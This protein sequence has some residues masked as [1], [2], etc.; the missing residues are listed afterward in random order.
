MGEYV[1]VKTKELNGAAL[2]WATA[3][4]DGWHPDSME[5]G[6]VVKFGEYR[7]AGNARQFDCYSPSTN[8]D[9]AHPL[10]QNHRI[11]IQC[12]D[13]SSDEDELWLAYTPCTMPLSK[14]EEIS[15]GTI[16]VAA[17]RALVF[18]KIGASVKVPA[19]LI[20]EVNS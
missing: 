13:C 19:E 10:I 17:C 5:A 4:A 20:C 14:D 3:I 8:W 1:E 18:D 6:V 7:L 12:F 11:S 16:L 9:Q 2:D 15:A